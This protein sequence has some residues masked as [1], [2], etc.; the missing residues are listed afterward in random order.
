LGGQKATSRHP[1]WLILARFPHSLPEGQYFV[2]NVDRKH[3][4]LNL[5]AEKH[6]RGGDWALVTASVHERGFPLEAAL[7]GLLLAIKRRS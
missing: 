6:Y 1:K 7:L 3:L 5:D 4:N 2:L